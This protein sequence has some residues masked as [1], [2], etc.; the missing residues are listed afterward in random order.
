MS[1]LG[2]HRRGDRLAPLGLTRSCHSVCAWSVFPEIFMQFSAIDLL[3]FSIFIPL[4]KANLL[5]LI[6]YVLDCA[7]GQNSGAGK[8]GRRDFPGE[9]GVSDAAKLLATGTATP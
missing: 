3:S 9:P 4:P 7:L 8:S 2:R 1:N 6:F 5:R